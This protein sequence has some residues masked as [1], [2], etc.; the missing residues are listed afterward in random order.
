[1]TRGQQ[2]VWESAFARHLWGGDGP[3][4]AAYYAGKAV[5]ALHEIDRRKLDDDMRA[6]LEDVIVVPR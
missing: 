2:A 6:M 4:E 3:E 5:Q 1:M